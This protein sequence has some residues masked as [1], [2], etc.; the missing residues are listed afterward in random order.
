MKKRQEELKELR[1][2]Q[3][4][5]EEQEAEAERE[6][7]QKLQESCPQTKVRSYDCNSD[8]LRLIKIFRFYYD[9]D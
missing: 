5:A 4:E 3:R 8:G 7:R 9:F 2:K 1:K 6:R